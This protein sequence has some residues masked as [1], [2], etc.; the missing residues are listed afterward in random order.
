MRTL[1]ER[2]VAGSWEIGSRPAGSSQCSSSPMDHRANA[3]LVAAPLPPEHLR[4]PSHEGRNGGNDALDGPD[5]MATACALGIL[6]N[7][8]H[9]LGAA[10]EATVRAAAPI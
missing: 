1:L 8:S 3:C 5:V 7:F 6:S 10:A 9:Q 2:A 4:P